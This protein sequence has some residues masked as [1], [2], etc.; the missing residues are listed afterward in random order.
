MADHPEGYPLS[1][2]QLALMICS[3]QVR[4]VHPPHT[5]RLPLTHTWFSRCLVCAVTCVVVQ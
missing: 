2:E 4:G 1:Q 5:Q 3:T